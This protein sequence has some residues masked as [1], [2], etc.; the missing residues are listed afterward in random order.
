M[1]TR[2]SLTPPFVDAVE[3][4]ARGE[5]WISDTLVR[6]FG[7]RVWTSGQ[8]TGKAFCLRTVDRDGHA[9]RRTF[10]P[11][12]S[13][14]PARGLGRLTAIARSWA[15][16]EL[17]VLKGPPPLS[18]MAKHQLARENTRQ[19]KSIAKRIRNI[20]LERAADTVLKTMR[21]EAK[22]PRAV[23]H[24]EHLQQLF[25]T[26]LP[27]AMRERPIGKLTPAAL[28]KALVPQDAKPGKIGK[29]RSFIFRIYDRAAQYDW[30]LHKFPEQLSVHINN[31]WMKQAERP[32]AW[33]RDFKKEDHEKLLATLSAETDRWQAAACIQMFLMHGA[34]LQRLLSARWDQ[35]VDDHWY[36][37]LPTE[38]KLWF[39][40]RIRIG[41]A[42]Q[43]ILENLRRQIGS[44]FGESVYLFPSGRDRGA[45]PIT[46][47]Q[48][49]WRQAAATIGYPDLRL[50]EYAGA[51]R[52]PNRPSYAL[53]IIHRYGW[54]T[55]EKA[56]LETLQ[57]RLRT[58]RAANIT[59]RF[60]Q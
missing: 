39:H 46:S 36:P 41:G 2:R 23:A 10:R 43:T 45:S 30:K 53:Y 27:A 3:P 51:L 38:R 14:D 5:I 56:D 31:R 32:P 22:T 17:R 1:P 35:L 19:R 57:M 54:V 28:A 26:S 60:G 58:Q 34:P 4:P 9:V 42:A 59:S 50:H 13:Y 11:S 55:E 12:Y 44:C 18:P 47:V 33:V 49:L 25:H 40:H 8:T 48:S 21:S 24:V 16:E 52:H 37:Y 6:G 15:R 20:S 7:L 29:L